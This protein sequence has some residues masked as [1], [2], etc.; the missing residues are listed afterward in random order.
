MLAGECESLGQRF[1]PT[2]IVV[3]AAGEPHGMQNPTDVPAHY[4]VFEFHGDYT[5]SIRERIKNYRMHY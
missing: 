1:G 5:P 2:D 3:Y 4:V